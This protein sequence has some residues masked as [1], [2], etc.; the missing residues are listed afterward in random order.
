MTNCCEDFGLSVL[1]QGK[2]TRSRHKF[3]FPEVYMLGHAVG[4][5]DA[6]KFITDLPFLLVETSRGQRFCVVIKLY[7]EAFLLYLGV[8]L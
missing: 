5:S 1:G 4:T 3:C 8:F 7:F 6:A 2:V